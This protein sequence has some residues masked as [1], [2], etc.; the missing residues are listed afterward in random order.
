[1]SPTKTRHRHGKPSKFERHNPVSGFALDKRGQPKQTKIGQNSA[2]TKQSTTDLSAELKNK[3]STPEETLNVMTEAHFSKHGQPNSSQ[4]GTVN[5]KPMDAEPDWNPDDIFSQ[6]RI[7]FADDLALLATTEAPKVNGLRGF[8]A[9]SETLREMTQKSLEHINSWCK[10]N[11]LSLSALKTYSAMF[12][13]RRNWR[14]RLS[15]PLQIDGAEIEIR[16]STKFLGVT[17][18]SKLFWNEHID[19]K[20]LKGQSFAELEQ[21]QQTSSL[22]IYTSFATEIPVPNDYREPGTSEDTIMCYI[23]GSILNNRVDSSSYKGYLGNGKAGELATKGSGNNEAQG[24]TL[25]V[26]RTVWKNALRKRGHRKIRERLKDMPLHFRSVWRPSYTKF[27]SDLEKIKLR[28]ATQYLTGNCEL[29]YHL[30]K[31]KTQSISKICP[32]CSME[33]ETMNHFIGQCPMWFNRRGRFFNCYYSS[34]S[35]IANRFP[36]RKIVG[37]IC[38]TNQPTVIAKAK[39][40][41]FGAKK[42]CKKIHDRGEQKA[43]LALSHNGTHKVLTSTWRCAKYNPPTKFMCHIYL[44]LA[45]NSLTLGTQPHNHSADGSLP[46]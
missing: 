27:L 35:E 36:L 23:D 5:G 19:Q 12:T 41:T 9:E 44:T 4:E 38:S 25:P 39:S 17:L 16:N 43:A 2:H 14:D 13:W 46:A 34:I 42:K 8:D 32:H 26:P 24:V 22:N 37:Y 3:N 10:E 40:G 7:G 11:G 31:Y 6:R 15:K 29:N 1:M 18:D 45:D 30:N 21:D 20:C 33:E 28:A